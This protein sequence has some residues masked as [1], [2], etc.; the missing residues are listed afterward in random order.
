MFP[1]FN[2]YEIPQLKCKFKR[3]SISPQRMAWIVKI[4]LIIEEKSFFHTNKCKC[5]S[6]NVEIELP[7]CEEN[8]HVF[9]CSISNPDLF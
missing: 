3:L 1:F 9:P 8:G 2:C 5:M 7:I 4:M 6:V